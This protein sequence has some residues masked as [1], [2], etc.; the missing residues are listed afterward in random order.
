MT[1]P[2]NLQSSKATKTKFHRRRP[3]NNY[4]PNKTTKSISGTMWI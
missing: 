4:R 3:Y 1:Y 2:P